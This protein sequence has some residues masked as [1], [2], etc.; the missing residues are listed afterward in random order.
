MM[1]GKAS[2]CPVRLTRAYLE[3][4]D[5]LNKR[6]PGLNAVTQLNPDALKEAAIL[7]R[8]RARG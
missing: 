2:S 3:R 5:A 1:E 6:G 8:E 4:I 7:D